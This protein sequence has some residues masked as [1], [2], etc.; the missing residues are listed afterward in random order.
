MAWLA[1]REGYL[2]LHFKKIEEETEAVI[3]SG[4]WCNIESFAWATDSRHLLYILDLNEKE[5]GHVYRADIENP[6]EDPFNVT[7][8]AITGV[9]FIQ[10]VDTGAPQII[11]S[12]NK[13]SRHHYDLYR[14]DLLTG[15]E[16]LI[17]KG[18][19]DTWQWLVDN[20]AAL[21]GR[22]RVVDD[23]EFVLEAYLP[24]KGTWK[25]KMRW[26]IHEDVIF[27]GFSSDNRTAWMISNMESDRLELC[28]FNVETGKRET[29][30]GD[31]TVDLSSVFIGPR[32]RLPMAALSYP[33]YPKVSAINKEIKPDLDALLEKG[34]TGL[35]ILSMN[36]KED[37]WTIEIFDDKGSDYY[38]YYR[39]QKIKVRIGANRLD[40]NI[41]RLADMLPITIQ[42][43]DGF[44]LPG[45][46]TVPK[47]VADSAIPTVL[48][49]HGGPWVRDYW[50]LDKMVQFLANRG[51]AVLQVNYRGSKGYGKKFQ[52]AAVD[53]FGAAMHTDLIDSVHWVVSKGIAD[54]ENV[55]IVGGS[56]GG[57]AALMGLA[58]TP[59]TFACGVSINGVSDF[60]QFIRE[61]QHNAPIRLKPGI[62]TWYTYLGNPA[63]SEQAKRIKS[64]SPLYQNQ[65]IV[66][67]ILIVYG[68]RDSRVSP[69]NSIYMIDALETAGK[70]VTVLDFMNEGH[71][72]ARIQNSK[73]LYKSLEAFL[74]DHLGGRDFGEETE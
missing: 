48:L 33:D 22:I 71:G 53:E 68:E 42:S 50:G 62:Q 6:L 52:Q 26:G 3:T 10:P 14:V 17:E 55:A 59:E 63:D 12:Q 31:P 32:S 56:Y 21:R 7:P 40:I 57:Y 45:Y 44:Q 39:D 73:K 35:N 51:Y 36:D 65:N 16:H 67:P 69:E 4:C 15:K 24:T 8:E 1:Y 28:G 19:A 70:D 29:V 9:Q 38:I 25:K 30:F 58:A 27:M 37:I 46:L 61:L 54:P 23:G 5:G 60:N 72:I 49:V 47:G 13:N 34:H 74:S 20:N 43:R 11:L 66:R 18:G 2:R 41:S 64:K